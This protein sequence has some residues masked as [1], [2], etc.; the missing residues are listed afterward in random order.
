MNR[1]AP[2]TPLPLEA[3]AASA[4]TALTAPGREAVRTA[5]LANGMRI[6]VWP[7]HNIPNVALYNWVRAGSRN[8]V[9][10]ITGLAHFFE[11]MMFNGTARRKSGDFDKLMEAQGGANNAFTSDDITVYQDWF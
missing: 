2:V 11:H 6:I 9:P 7:V 3:R 5:T 1:I 8:E 4:S 10:G